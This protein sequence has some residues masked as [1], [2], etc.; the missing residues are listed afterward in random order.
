MITN[1]FELPKLS[2]SSE[3]Q[4]VTVKDQYTGEVISS[5]RINGKTYQPKVPN[6]GAYN[7]VVGEE[8]NQQ[9]IENVEA[10][11]KNNKNNKHF[12]LMKICGLHIIFRN[13]IFN[14]MQEQWKR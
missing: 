12:I 5:L 6:K 3:D 8:K 11:K 10:L 9:T 4:V 2:F 7:I 1:G 14:R 13:P